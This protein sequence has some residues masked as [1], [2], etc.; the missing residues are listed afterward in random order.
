MKRA[1]VEREE[2]R[3]RASCGRNAT[4]EREPAPLFSGWSAVAD[5][6]ETSV[7]APLFW[8]QVDPGNLALANAFRLAV[9]GGRSAHA[10]AA[11]AAAAADVA[12][13]Q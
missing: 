13:P 8:G 7:V 10:A 3:R 11:G 12:A 4:S 1:I 5:G 2:I 9:E 6:A